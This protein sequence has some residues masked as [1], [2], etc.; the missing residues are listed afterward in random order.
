MRYDVEKRNEA[1]RKEG[2][3]SGFLKDEEIEIFMAS[4]FLI[5]VSL[6]FITV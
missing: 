3:R 2:T 5:N 4:D 6:L 1:E